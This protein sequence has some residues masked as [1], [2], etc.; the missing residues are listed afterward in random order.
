MALALPAF[1]APSNGSAGFL[2]I[3]PGSSGTQFKDFGMFLCRMKTAQAPGSESCM[4]LFNQP[5]GTEVQNPNW[6]ECDIEIPG[7]DGSHIET[8]AHTYDNQTFSQRPYL[9]YKIYHDEPYWNNYFTYGIE[10]TPDYAAWTLDGKPYR[11]A[12]KTADGKMRDR[13]WNTSDWEQTRDD[14]YDLCWLDVWA[15]TPMRCAFDIWWSDASWAWDWLGRWDDTYCG[16]SIFVSYFA[17]YAYTPGVGPDGTDFTLEDYDDFTGS[18]TDF[19]LVRWEPYNTCMREGK[20]VCTMACNGL[21]YDNVE[22]PE[23]AADTVN[24]EGTHASARAELIRNRDVSLD[25]RA[26]TI[27]YRIAKPGQIKLSLYDLNGRTVRTLVTAN[28]TAGNHSFTLDRST[29]AAGAY[30]I[31]LQTP[32]AKRVRQMIS[33]GG[34]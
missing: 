30:Y 11:L 1:S 18:G 2:Y 17:Y 7:S 13:C 19:D 5:L 29:L 16:A 12:E 15:Q 34:K 25:Y 9:Y 8:V 3:N 33:I 32:S 6:M 23:D 28:Q 21:T 10:W 31:S 27:Q 22:I 24:W 4:G 26:G 20:A 14:T